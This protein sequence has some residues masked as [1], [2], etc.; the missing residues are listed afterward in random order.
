[1]YACINICAGESCSESESLLTSPVRCL[2]L[3]NKVQQPQSGS[4][5]IYVRIAHRSANIVLTTEQIQSYPNLNNNS[6][7]MYVM[8]SWSVCSEKG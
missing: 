1:M 6:T 2:F 3:N 4:C 7:E 8:E 5:Y